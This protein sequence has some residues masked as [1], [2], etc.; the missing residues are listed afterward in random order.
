M[1]YDSNQSRSTTSSQ[2]YAPYGCGMPNRHNGL[3]ST[4]FLYFFLKSF[5][6]WTCFTPFYYF[7][8]FFKYLLQAYEQLGGETR[9]KG[10]NSDENL[11]SLSWNSKSIFY[12][13]MNNLPVFFFNFLFSDSAPPRCSFSTKPTLWRRCSTLVFSS[14]RRRRFRLIRGAVCQIEVQVESGGAQNQKWYVRARAGTFLI[15]SYKL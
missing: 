1:I 9:H 2:S 5:F 8:P 11:N 13:A 3:P 6:V 15:N 7:L 12:N 14:S 4:G 10:K